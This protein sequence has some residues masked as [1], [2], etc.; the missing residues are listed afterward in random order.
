VTLESKDLLVRKGR[1]AT[2]ESKDQSAYKVR[3]AIQVFK[4]YRESRA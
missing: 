1:K 4:A 3:K 2:K